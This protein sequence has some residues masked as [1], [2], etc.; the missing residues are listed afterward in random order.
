MPARSNELARSS[1]G[2]RDVTVHVAIGAGTRTVRAA[3]STPREAQ[4][5]HGFPP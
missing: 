3:S 4:S 2:L 5:P 1:H